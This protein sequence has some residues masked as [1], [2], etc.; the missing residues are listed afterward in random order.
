MKQRIVG[1][2]QDEERHWVAVLECHHTQHLRHNPPWTNRPWVM[3]D[4]GRERHIGAVLNCKKC[5][6][7]TPL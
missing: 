1:Y 7:E 5:A 3:T 4:E 2:Q 6:T